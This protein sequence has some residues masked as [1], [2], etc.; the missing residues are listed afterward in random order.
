MKKLN[1][2]GSELVSL[3]YPIARKMC[4]KF[5]RRYLQIQKGIMNLEIS[6][7]SEQLSDANYMPP[8]KFV[9]DFIKQTTTE[10]E[11]RSYLKNFTK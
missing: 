3:P 5:L 9:K 4:D 11:G 7:M 10:L 8:E 6:Y 1:Y 2:K